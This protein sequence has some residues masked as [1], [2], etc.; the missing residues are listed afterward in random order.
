MKKL[1]LLDE[2]KKIRFWRNL[3]FQVNIYIFSFEE[4]SFSDEYKKRVFRGNYLIY[5]TNKRNFEA[6]L[7][8]SKLTYCLLVLP[9]ELLF[10]HFF[11]FFSKCFP[12]SFSLFLCLEFSINRKN[13][14]F[15]LIN[16]YS[17]EKLLWS[18]FVGKLNNLRKS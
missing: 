18:C 11:L 16:G 10:H 13:M 17:V 14:Q 4:T 3:L 1:V 7:A 5:L 8:L 15:S 6:A 9:L 12:Y 2:Y